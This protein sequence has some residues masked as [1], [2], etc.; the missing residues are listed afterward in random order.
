MIVQSDRHPFSRRAL[1]LPWAVLTAAGAVAWT[2]TL[3]QARGMGAEP[4]TMGMAFPVFVAFWV[5]MMAAMMLPAI[6]P[7]A[8]A[9]SRRV[10]RSLAFGVGFLI[11]WAAYG[12]A[13]FLAFVG[14]ERLAEASPGAARWLGVSIFA[15]AGAYQLSPW[16][17]RA[18]RHC[19]AGHHE[20]SGGLVDGM[21]D[22]AVCVGCCW[23]LMAILVAMGAMNIAVMAALAVVIFAEKILPAPRLV[24]ALAGVGFLVFAV[25]AAIDPSLLHGLSP[26]EMGGG[27]H[28]G[29][30]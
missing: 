5:A 18:V 11:P 21:R 17:M 30:V 3:D 13:A 2:L 22:G 19:R 27:M 6:G 7:S 23:A 1:V 25:M 12:A 8:A 10:S 29:A 28:M 16:K 14:A 15:V 9:M 26:A 4:G 20:A 24:A